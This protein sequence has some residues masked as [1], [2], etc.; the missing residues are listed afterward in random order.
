MSEPDRREMLTRLYDELGQIQP[1]DERGQQVLTAARE[2]IRRALEQSEE[3][4]IE[5]EPLIERL[6]DTVAHFED[7]HLDL[8]MALN[9]VINSLS[10][11]GL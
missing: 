3:D 10:N 4:T 5:D 7:S 8:T 1:N 9:T 11:M 2:D 6:Q